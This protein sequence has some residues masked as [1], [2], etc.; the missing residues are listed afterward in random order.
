LRQNEW[1]DGMQSLS[2]ERQ[3]AGKDGAAQ[4]G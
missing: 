3:F 1:I 4:R 2:C